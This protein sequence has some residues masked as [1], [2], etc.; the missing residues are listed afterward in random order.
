VVNGFACIDRAAGAL[1]IR[2]PMPPTTVLI[3]GN[4]AAVRT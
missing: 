3:Y 4:P 1:G 2:M